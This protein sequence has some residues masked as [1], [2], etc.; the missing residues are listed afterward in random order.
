[1]V[2]V[3]DDDRE[4]LKPQV[5]TMTVGG[6]LPA[7]F[8]EF[9][10][11]DLLR[12]QTHGECLEA[13][14]FDAE[15]VREAWVILAPAPDGLEAKGVAVELLGPGQVGNRYTDAIDFDHRRQCR[16]RQ[17]EERDQNGR[18]RHTDAPWASSGPDQDHDVQGPSF[19]ASVRDR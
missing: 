15:Q 11:L 10:E 5:L 18:E 4:V 12:P 1:L 19:R 17:R 16:E 7:V 3:A 6:I 9:N 8:L 2:H 13:G 14:A